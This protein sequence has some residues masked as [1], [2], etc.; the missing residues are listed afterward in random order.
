MLKAID[1]GAKISVIPINSTDGKARYRV[2]IG[3][4]FLNMSISQV[5]DLRNKIADRLEG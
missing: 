1:G 2:Q 5:R 3:N 4:V